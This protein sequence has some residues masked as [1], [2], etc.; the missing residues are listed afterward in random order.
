M[1]YKNKIIRNE[2]KVKSMF[3]VIREVEL[4]RHGHVRCVEDHGILLEW[5]QWKSNT[6]RSASRPRK[7]GSTKDIKEAAAQR[8]SPQVTGE[9]KGV[10]KGS[11][12]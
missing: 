11:S 3:K 10:G 6:G 1:R 5:V 8:W 12:T 2:L 4:S 9:R 7:Q